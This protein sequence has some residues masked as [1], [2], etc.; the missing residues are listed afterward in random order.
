MDARS[1]GGLGDLDFVKVDLHTNTWTYG[2]RGDE[3]WILMDD[4]DG[5][6]NDK[7]NDKYVNTN[8]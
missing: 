7:I 1:G 4:D 8:Y 2:G 3:G 6:A 5:D